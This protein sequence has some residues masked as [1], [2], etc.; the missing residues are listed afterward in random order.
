[1]KSD[2]QLKKDII[3]ACRIL[4]H[5]NCSRIRAQRAFLIRIFPDDA[6]DQPRFGH[7]ERTS[8][9]ISTAKWSKATI[10]LLKLGSMRP[11]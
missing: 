1:M 10:R 11:S 8:H 5:R 6:A 7:G 4:S 3:S 9:R 2:S